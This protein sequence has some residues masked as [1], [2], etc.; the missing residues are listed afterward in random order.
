MDTDR[1]DN[2]SEGDGL[3]ELLHRLEWLMNRCHMKNH[4]RHGPMGGLHRGQGRALKL[5]AKHPGLK[6]QELAALLDMRTQSLGELL[7][8]L[9][10]GGYI[11]REPSEADRRAM[12]IRLTEQGRQAAEQA[13]KCGDADAPFDCLTPEE[14]QAF[15]GYMARVIESL[16]AQL[17]EDDRPYGHGCGKGHSC[18]GHGA[19]GE[20]HGC[21]G[22]HGEGHRE[23][24]CGSHGHHGKGHLGHDHI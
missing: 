1:V 22:H 2:F 23:H 4:H 10:R 19:R 7:T 24:G 18:G 13:G 5:L 12:D 14:R 17:G 9:E 15:G 21:G 6:Q 16:E 8:K 20:H 11:E 3:F